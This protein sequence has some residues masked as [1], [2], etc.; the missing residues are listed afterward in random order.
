MYEGCARVPVNCDPH[1]E[2]RKAEHLAEMPKHQIA[3]LQSVIYR[4]RFHNIV[5]SYLGRG[6]ERDQVELGKYRI[7]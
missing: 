2:I 6:N 5:R 7:M 3:E 1:L 4:H